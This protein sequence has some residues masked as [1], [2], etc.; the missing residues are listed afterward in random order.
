MHKRIFG[1]IP[2]DY[3]R[4]KVEEGER[5]HYKLRSTAKRDIEE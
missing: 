2:W 5:K 3:T 1:T 4:V